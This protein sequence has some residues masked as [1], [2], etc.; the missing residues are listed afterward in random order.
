MGCLFI[1]FS[2]G[3]RVD[4]VGILVVCLSRLTLGLIFVGC[5]VMYD[6]GWGQCPILALWSF[7]KCVLAVSQMDLK[8]LTLL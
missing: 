5:D 7:P 2:L 8:I 6:G 3:W 4:V 1:G